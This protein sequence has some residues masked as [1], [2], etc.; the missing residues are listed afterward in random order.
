MN[1]DVSSRSA[2]REFELLMMR[3]LDGEISKSDA[4]RLE[5]HLKTCPSCRKAFSEYRKLAAATANVPPPE[6]SQEEWDTY[7][8]NVFNR[9]ER[10]TAWTVLGLGLAAVAAYLLYLL[11]TWLIGTD[12]MPVW[13]RV[14]IAVL[15]LGVVGL[16]LSVA[17]EKMVLR[18]T[19][20]YKG[21]Q[22]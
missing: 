6:V 22:R 11:S 7:R 17:R 19:D 20:K 14:A 15:V 12:A 16:F 9:M 21:V 1:E 8:A 13:A 4:A 18:R 10:G 5:A 2:C 3:H